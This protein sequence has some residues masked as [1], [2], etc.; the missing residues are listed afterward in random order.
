MA[1]SAINIVLNAV[2]DLFNRDVKAAADTMEKSSAKMQQSANKAGQAIEQSLG[3]GQLRQKIAA[4]TA[5]IDEQKQITREFMMELEKLRQKRDTMS[6]MDV[7][8]QK[9]VRKEIEQT[10]AAIKDQSI[11]V[12]ELTAKKQGFTQQLSSTNKTLSGSRAALNGLATSF[13][14]VSSVLAIVNDDNKQLR[15]V[16]MATNAALN[17]GAAVMQVKDLQ[18]QFGSLSAVVAKVGAFMAANPFL[19][20]AAV[21][22]SVIA[23]TAAWLD[24]TDAIEKAYEAQKKYASEVEAYNNRAL[25]YLLK[26]IEYEKN[27]AKKR[28]QLAGKSESEIAQI[29]LDYSKKRID[30]MRKFQSELSDDSQLRVDLILQIQDAEREY[31]LQVLDMKIAQKNAREQNAKEAKKEAD[32]IKKSSQEVKKAE[33][34]LINWLEKKRFETGEKAKKKAAEDAKKLTGANLIAGTAIAPVL[35]Q[36]KIDPKSYS[37]IVQDFDRLMTDMAMAVERLGEDIAISLGEALGNQLSGQGNGIEGFVQSVVGQLGNFVKTVGKMLIAYG[38]SVQKFQTAFIQ[39]QVAVAAGIAM[40]AL[41]TAVASQMRTGPSVSAFAD[42]GIVSGPTLGLMGEYPGARS[43]PEVI[44]PLDKLKTLM[45]PEQSSG[46]VAQ[47]HIS[48]R[49]LAIVLERYNKDSRR[50]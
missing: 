8:G 27:L 22:A 20:G 13:S 23:L 17:F 4:V 36:V 49:D 5:E 47:T 7:Q 38:I 19:I 3:S 18:A 24:D 29:E 10:K 45:K 28:A 50:G 40:V 1:L 31:N 34:D 35:V 11:A 42:G 16:L 44:A 46:Y 15:H 25:A 39:P 43:N 21:I 12:S 9:K 48:G 6:K 32:A 14:S 33:T 37:Q 41:G 26:R 2:T 30:T